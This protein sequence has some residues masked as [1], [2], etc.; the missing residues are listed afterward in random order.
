MVRE[1]G[2]RHK[3][4]RSRS[5]Q[6]QKKKQQR[7][8]RGVRPALVPNASVSSWSST[9]ML[10]PHQPV[11]PRP[12]LIIHEAKQKDGSSIQ[13]SHMDGWTDGTRTLPPICLPPHRL[14]LV[15]LDEGSVGEERLVAVAPCHTQGVVAH[16]RHLERLDLV[17][18]VLRSEDLPARHLLHAEGAAALEAKV[19]G[20]DGLCR[21]RKRVS[22]RVSDRREQASWVP[23][24]RRPLS[25]PM[26]VGAADLPAWGLLVRW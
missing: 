19:A 21:G 4:R 26:M 3:R 9:H 10:G 1:D 5:K 25:M 18:H 20:V 12:H 11:G 17:A 16:G 15:V 2:G 24:E 8:R 22:G 6:K 14:A 7:E 23:E 13:S